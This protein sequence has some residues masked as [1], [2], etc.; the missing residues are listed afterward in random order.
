MLVARNVR[1]G[2]ALATNVLRAESLRSRMVGL[3]GRKSL[4]AGEAMWIEPCSQ[5]HTFFMA[6]PIDVLFLDRERRVVRVVP[7]LVPWRVSPW[8]W[9]ARSVL[10][11]E[12]GALGGKVEEGDRLEIE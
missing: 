9:G 5:V 10:E 8:V 12:G 2:E 11:F 3:L 7:D 6:F 4:E 1:S